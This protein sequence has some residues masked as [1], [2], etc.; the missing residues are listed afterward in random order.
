MGVISVSTAGY[1]VLGWGL[2]VTSTFWQPCWGSATW[3]LQLPEF[4]DLTTNIRYWDKLDGRNEWSTC[5]T[6]GV[7]DF[8]KI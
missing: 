4:E 5:T 8:N 3:M 6:N 2:R 7:E 1:T